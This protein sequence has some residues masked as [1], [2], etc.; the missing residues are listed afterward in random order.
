MQKDF[1]LNTEELKKQ[2]K[3]S[4]LIVLNCF[5]YYVA[6]Q[7]H[8]EQMLLERMLLNSVFHIYFSRHQELVKQRCKS[9]V[10]HSLTL[11]QRPHN[12][13]KPV[14]SQDTELSTL[15][16]PEFTNIPKRVIRKNH[17]NS[18]WEFFSLITKIFLSQQPEV[19]FFSC[20]LYKSIQ[21]CIK[22]HFNFKE[23]L[24]SFKSQMNSSSFKTLPALCR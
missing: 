15:C 9:D 5:S 4:S 16:C 19:N 2:L 23:M 20:L 3:K 8:K 22:I 21:H 24:F 7:T 17:R 12:Q 14:T 18:L 10:S 6:I 11:R 1:R 13:E